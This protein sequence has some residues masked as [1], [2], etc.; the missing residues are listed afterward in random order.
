MKDI[1]VIYAFAL[2]VLI[3][4]AVLREFKVSYASLCSMTSAIIICIF[5]LSQ[6]EEIKEFLQNVQQQIKLPHEYFELIFKILGISV[7]SEVSI[8]LCRDQQHSA[9]VYAL[10]IF[11]KCSIILLSLPVLSDVLDVI[12][13]LLA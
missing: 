12:G 8:S 6:F 9:L 1:S 3:I 7:L 2:G 11:S 13:E 5:A 4:C 10:D